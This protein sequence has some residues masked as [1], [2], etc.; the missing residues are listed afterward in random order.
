VEGGLDSFSA[1]KAFDGNFGTRWASGPEIGNPEWIAFELEEMTTVT[2]V[3]IYWETAFAS[4]YEL[5]TS[6]S[7]LNGPWTT[8]LT[9]TTAGGLDII[10]L[11]GSGSA[12]ETQFLRLLA[13]ERHLTDYLSLHEIRVNCAGSLSGP[14][15]VAIAAPIS[16]AERVCQDFAVHARTTVTFAGLESTIRGGDV[17][18]SPGTAITGAYNIEDGGVVADTDLTFADY[19]RSAYIGAI[20]PQA[21][22]NTMA[23]EMGG[24]TFTPGTYRSGSAIN[25]AFGT[26]VTLDGLNQANPKFLFQAG[27]TLV[28]AADTKFNLFNG[29]KAENVIWALGTAATLGARSVV[30]GSILAGTA[31]TFGTNSVVNGCA[32]AESAV[33]FES[34]GIVDRT[35]YPDIF[36]NE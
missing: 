9:E 33:T 26:T 19:A 5:Q 2:S 20:A 4:K 31:I 1:A 28:T 21:G 16:E 25:I 10:D 32:L 13:I 27:S 23:I 15:S 36:A 34:G 30:E 7:G 22:G 3:E 29:A 12:V 11:S 8:I 6:A 17:G 24:Q 18:V 14:M 35:V